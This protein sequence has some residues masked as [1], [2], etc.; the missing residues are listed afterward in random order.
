LQHG[1]EFIFS[2]ACFEYVAVSA[3]RSI[4]VRSVSADGSPDTVAVLAHLVLDGLPVRFVG[5]F[6]SSAR[7]GRATLIALPLP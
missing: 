7:R 3:S 6:R 2:F 5:A 1:V 4:E